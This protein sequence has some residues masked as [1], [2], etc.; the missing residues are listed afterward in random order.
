MSTIV[1]RAGKGSPLTNT[2]VD[3]NFTNLNTDKAELSGAAFTGA[4]TTN[5]TFDG[6]DV[7]TDGTK[8]DGIEASADVT[9]VT[10][11]T[12]AGALMDSEVTNLAEVKA[13][14]SSDY[15]TAAQG[16]TADAALPKSG[17]A[18]TGAITTNSTFD[19]RD[20]A[21]DGT[22]L[23]TVETNADVTDTTNVTAAGALMDSE[24]T[25]IASVKALDQGVATG[26]SPTFVDVTATSL[27]ISGNIDVD[28]TTNLDV[29]DIDGAVDMA[30]TLK[31]GSTISINEPAQTTYGLVS[32]V[33]SVYLSSTDGTYANLTIR[34]EASTSTDY[35]QIRDS[36]NAVV[37]N[38]TSLGGLTTTPV[39][40][41]HAVFNE[42][43]VDAD[44]RVESDTNA[45]GLM[46]DASTSTVGVNRAAAS[47]VAL[48]V[49]ATATNS[50]TYAFEACN[51]NSNTKFIVRSDGYSGFYK[52]SNAGGF[53]HNTNGAITITPDAGGHFVFN[54]DGVD[55]DFRVE[56]NNDANALFV[57][58]ETGRTTVK[59]LALSV[60]GVLTG[61][62]AISVGTS[63]TNITSA[64]DFGSL[65]IVSGNNAGNIFT[66]LVFFATTIGATVITGGTVS[67]GPAGRTYSVVS[68]KLKLAMSSGTSS[69]KATAFMGTL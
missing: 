10:N 64:N 55:A 30:S 19:G 47:V 23:D 69:V 31:V 67:G 37:A 12:A 58:G 16:T 43:G 20:V 57:D 38:L 7:A 5:S 34:K 32:K 53:I 66:D 52:S 61:E 42:G 24:L 18:M 1:T 50:S 45:N 62:G 51:A 40:G 41:G 11:V 56:S 54:E 15:A 22:K 65:C 29:V 46:L 36:G 17:G 25:S 27:D 21:T 3:S 8:L 14:A 4:I 13:F 9:D 6:R 44:F 33:K 63:A 59:E 68:S 49:N 28:G 39:A 26:D 60:G 2:E 35:L 48:S